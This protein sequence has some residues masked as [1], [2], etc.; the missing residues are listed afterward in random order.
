[1]GI[2]SLNSAILY[3]VSLY[4]HCHLERASHCHFERAQQVEK[5]KSRKYNK[6]PGPSAMK[7]G[8][9]LAI[10]LIFDTSAKKR[11]VFLAAIRS[12]PFPSTK[13]ALFM[14]KRTHF[15]VTVIFPLH[16]RTL[17]SSWTRNDNLE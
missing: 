10:E 16:P 15:S 3:I 13:T 17:P 1:M 5:S 12:F 4:F 8:L 7:T 9:F 14:D 2:P 11:A 6:Y